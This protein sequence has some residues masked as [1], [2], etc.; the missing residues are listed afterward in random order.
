MD[1][2]FAKVAGLDVHRKTVQWSSTPGKWES[3][4]RG[5]LLRHDDQ[6]PQSPGRLPD[7]NGCD[8]RGSRSHRG[9]VETCVER[10]GGPV[11]VVV[12]PVASDVL[13]KSGR[14][15]LRA[16]LRDEKDIE[17]IA[18]LAR[19]VLRKKIPQLKL[20]LEGHCREHHRFMN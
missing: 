11:H 8:A 7:S 2:L 4:Q 10:L 1:T 6:G 14:D 17:K 16:L 13:G 9:V 20:A 18:E 3:A 5:P 12:G 15:M 19:G